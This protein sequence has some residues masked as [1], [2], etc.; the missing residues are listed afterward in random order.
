MAT[1]CGAQG[2]AIRAPMSECL[3][4]PTSPLDLIGRHA[5]VVFRD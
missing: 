1:D 5:D 4:D 2:V 3:G